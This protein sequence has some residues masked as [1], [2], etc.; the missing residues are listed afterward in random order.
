MLGLERK[1]LVLSPEE[2]KLTAYHEAGHALVGVRTPCLDPIHK[3]T[4]VPRG[5]AL[6][7]TYSLPEGDRHNYTREYLLAR[8]AMAYGGRAAEEMVF[9]SDKITTGAAQDIKQATDMARRMI[10]QFGMNEAVGLVAVGDGGEKVFLGRQI[11]ESPRVSEATAALIDA[12]LKRMLSGAY[13]R[14][15]TILIENEAILHRLASA[16]IEKETL[17]HEDVEKI[18]RI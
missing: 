15:K 6:G 9:G 10:T 16:L 2:K 11:I 3:V 1:S 12:E 4:I 13:E 17:D 18:T 8:L 5:R 7:I 14:A